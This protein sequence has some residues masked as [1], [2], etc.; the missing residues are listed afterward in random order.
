MNNIILFDDENWTSFLPLTYTRPI[1]ELRIGIDTIREKWEYALAGKVSYITKDY[2]T[3]KFPINI[4]TENILI[5]G[6]VLPTR[7]LELLIKDLRMNEAI[8]VNDQL[9]AAKIDNKQF[10]KM[11]ETNE[12]DSIQGIELGMTEE[13]VIFQLTSPTELFSR[14]DFWLKKDFDRKTAGRKSQ[15]LSDTNT[16]IGNKDLVFLEDGAVVE[17]CIFNT[18]NGPI[19]IGKNALIME[20]SMIRGPFAALDHVVVKMGAKIYGP[21]TLGPYCRGGGEIN[22]VMMYA[23]SN[24][25][26]DGYLG[27]S[28]IGEWCNLGADTNASNLKNNYEEV[29]LWSYATDSFLKTG[30]QFCGLIMGDHSKSGIN[31]M[32]NTGTVVGVSVNIFGDGFPRNFVPSFAWG[33]A[34]GYT[35]YEISKAI[36]TCRKVYERRKKEF[37]KEDEAILTYIFENSKKYRSWE[38]SSPAEGK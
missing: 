6:S 37:T 10:N 8:L 4:E 14:N 34:S 3:E 26:H 27:N 5:N 16:V 32:F 22:N 33:G 12:M 19:Y 29:K 13:D 9:V 38:K 7:K 30:L 35:T 18:R 15:P 28:V 2:L 23:N 20:G 17:A 24:K 11:V 31:T 25:G 36:A 1:G 21:T